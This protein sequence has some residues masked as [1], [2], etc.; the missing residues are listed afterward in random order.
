M[1]DEFKLESV[2]DDAG[3]YLDA[4]GKTDLATLT[5]DEWMGFLRT[6][7]IAYQEAP[8]F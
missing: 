2:S 7:I 3:Q 1:E 5:R 4:L 8:P 6:V